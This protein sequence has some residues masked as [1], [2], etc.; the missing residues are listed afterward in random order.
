MQT[1]TSHVP[2]VA[3]SAGA[4]LLLSSTPA[5]VSCQR[6]LLKY[7]AQL[8]HKTTDIHAPLKEAVWNAKTEEADA[9]STPKSMLATNEIRY[10]SKRKR[11]SNT[12]SP[13][14][15]YRLKS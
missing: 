11:W 3:A 7:Q 10:L 15:C 1:K 14:G 5:A 13:R 8:T 2:R 9:N 12:D 6:K 4:G